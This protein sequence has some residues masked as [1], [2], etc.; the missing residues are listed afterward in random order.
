[1]NAPSLFTGMAAHEI[2][3]AVFRPGLVLETVN[4]GAK[5]WVRAGDLFH[6]HRRHK[7]VVVLLHERTGT[8][9]RIPFF[10][11]GVLEEHADETWTL[12]YRVK[13]NENPR[14]RIRYDLEPNAPDYGETP[15]RLLRETLQA[16]GNDIEV[17]LAAL[18][19]SASPNAASARMILARTRRR[20]AG[21]SHVRYCGGGHFEAVR[22]NL[23]VL[24]WYGDDKE[25]S[26]D[27]GPYEGTVVEPGAFRIT[28]D[29]VAVRRFLDTL[30]PR[31]TYAT[32]R[33]DDRPESRVP[34][35]FGVAL[36]GRSET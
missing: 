32:I 25:H 10:K 13:A 14:F 27:L 29:D 5:T 2:L 23:R 26:R 7:S 18:H 28:M 17:T 12:G 8:T 30:T 22:P 24:G 16:K 9:I 35:K 20:Y 21:A 34:G 31:P 4:P 19:E 6:V 1:M 33:N 36:E 3:P 15:T 11:D